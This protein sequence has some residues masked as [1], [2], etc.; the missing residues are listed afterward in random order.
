MNK[1]LLLF[2]FLITEITSI[3]FML[4]YKVVPTYVADSASYIE[5]ARYLKQGEGLLISPYGTGESVEDNLRPMQLWPPGYPIMIYAL[6]LFSINAETAAEIIPRVC[7]ILLPIVFFLVLRYIVRDNIA[8]I[9]SIFSTFMFYTI[10]VSL[11]TMSDTPFL[12]VV[13]VSIIFLFMSLKKEKLRYALISGLISGF[14]LLIRNV[15]CSLVLA[16]MLG[17]IAAFIF[18]LIS[19]RYCVKALLLYSAGVIFIYAPYIIRNIVVCHYIQPFATLPSGLTFFSNIKSYFRAFSDSFFYNVYSTKVI[20][21]I[22]LFLFG[23]NIFYLLKDKSIIGNNRS[24]KKILYRLILFLYAASGTLVIILGSI[25]CDWWGTAG[26][27]HLMQYNWIFVV[28]FMSM[29]IFIY[30]KIRKILKFNIRPYVVVLIGSFIVF[31]TILFYFRTIELAISNNYVRN[32]VNKVENKVAY[33]SNLPKDT[34]IASNYGPWLRILTKRSVRKMLNIT[35][36]ELAKKVSGR[37]DIIIILFIDGGSSFM[38]YGYPSWQSI[39]AKGNIPEGY[40]VISNDSS[41][42]VLFCP[43]NI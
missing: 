10:F 2:I 3:L 1:K 36:Q 24:S 38:N 6:E 16:A 12:F 21:S 20:I 27:R 9:C 13:L 31:I 4:F 33:V 41:A 29:A 5:A 28:Y 8:A 17:L 23:V 14:G 43:K 35:P 39:V 19:R 34:Y 30:N 25:E 37:R 42:I 15:G 22:F 40:K 7:F 26:V 18:K 32:I 11:I